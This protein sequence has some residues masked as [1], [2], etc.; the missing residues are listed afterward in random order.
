MK[1]K[2]SGKIGKMP[3]TPFLKGKKLSL[4]KKLTKSKKN[5]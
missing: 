1:S 2:F 3:K 5:T 4:V